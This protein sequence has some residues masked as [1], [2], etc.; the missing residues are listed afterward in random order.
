MTFSSR[1]YVTVLPVCAI[2]NCNFHVFCEFCCMLS[3]YWYICIFFNSG[4]MNENNVHWFCNFITLMTYWL[5]LILKLNVNTIALIQSNLCLH[6]LV[7]NG[8][9]SYRRGPGSYHCL[10]LFLSLLIVPNTFVS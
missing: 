5:F 6:P 8:H 10:K 3:G 9:L 4:T 2:V 1:I 7:Y